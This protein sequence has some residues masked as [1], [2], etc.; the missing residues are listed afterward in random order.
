MSSCYLVCT[1]YSVALLRL[2]WLRRYNVH[3]LAGGHGDVLLLLSEGAVDELRGDADGPA[4]ALE[5]D[6]ERER[7]VDDDL[8]VDWLGALLRHLQVAAARVADPARD[9]Q[10]AE[11]GDE[12]LAGVA[13]LER[14]AGVGDQVRQPVGAAQHALVR[15]VRKALVGAVDGGLQGQGRGGARLELLQPLLQGLDLLLL[16]LLVG[17]RLRAG[18][19]SRNIGVRGR[20]AE[21]Q[22]GGHGKGG[23]GLGHRRL[24]LLGGGH[25]AG[26][27][28]GAG[29]SAGGAQG[30]THGALEGQVLG[31]GGESG[32]GDKR[33]KDGFDG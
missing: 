4:G 26:S 24:L 14:Q 6:A 11:G 33:G 19:E 16:Q 25:H 7:H 22:A 10:E 31:D 18:G 12:H 1:P 28:H 21:R 29:G 15:V 9:V 8:G 23:G 5:H 20:G 3:R 32:H 17:L 2:V 27:A 30:G 13:V